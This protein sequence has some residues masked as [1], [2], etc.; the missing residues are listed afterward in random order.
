VVLLFG[1]GGF[2]VAAVWF[3]PTDTLTRHVFRTAVLIFAFGGLMW[4]ASHLRAA[5]DVSENRRNSFPAADERALR[6]IRE[7][8]RVT[9][10]LAAE[11][12]R[13]MDLERNILAKLQRILPEL[14]VVY[15][16]HSRAGL[17]EG[18]HYGEVWYELGGR[19][20]MSR[21]TTE[22]IVLET[23]YHLAQVAP[24]ADAHDAQYAGH[25]LAAEPRGAALTYY[26]VWPLVVLLAAWLYFRG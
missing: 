9:V 5:R 25:P 3:A 18:E 11:D 1:I 16:A 6:Q 22:P 19:R 4:N 17:F 13:L 7:P 14:D 21:S 10:F 20:V 8:L 2:C 26:A 12:P 24:P 23:I 15:A